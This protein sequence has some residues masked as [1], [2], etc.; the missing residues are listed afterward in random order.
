[1]YEFDVSTVNYCDSEL[2][3]QN[4]LLKTFTKILIKLL[5]TEDLNLNGLLVT[6]QTDN[7]SPGVG[8]G[9]GGGKGMH[10]EG[11]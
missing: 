8:G 4:R 6:R 1:M 5:L 11:N 10:Q 7:T 9:G 3:T 2:A